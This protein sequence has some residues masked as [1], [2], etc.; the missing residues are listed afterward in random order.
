MT[1]FFLSCVWVEYIKKDRDRDT[2]RERH[3]ESH[4]EREKETQR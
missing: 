1:Y 3:R 2:Q 4:R